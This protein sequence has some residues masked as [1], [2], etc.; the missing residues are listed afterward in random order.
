MHS[1]KAQIL[2]LV[3]FKF[4]HRDDINMTEVLAGSS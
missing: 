1:R 3:K 4:N 2:T